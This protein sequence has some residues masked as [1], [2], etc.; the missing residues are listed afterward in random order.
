MLERR[1]IRCQPLQFA[2]SSAETFHH[3][4][5]RPGPWDGHTR[6][7]IPALISA[8][9]LPVQRSLLSMCLV[10][11]VQSSCPTVS[12]SQ[13]RLVDQ[14]SLPRRA[15]ISCWNWALLVSLCQRLASISNFPAVCL[16][17]CVEYSPDA[18]Q[19]SH[20]PCI[21]TRSPMLR[22]VSFPGSD[23]TV[24]ILEADNFRY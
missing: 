22:T 7:R 8:Q 16:P 2:F 19:V 4:Q 3:V 15:S 12:R 13:V 18:C 17:A 24:H 23:L 6:N 21:R 1:R 14:R 20:E 10:L 11:A 5:V 9:A